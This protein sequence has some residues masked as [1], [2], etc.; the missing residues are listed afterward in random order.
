MKKTFDKLY[1]SLPSYLLPK[2]QEKSK[3]RKRQDE[4]DA[5]RKIV[6]AKLNECNDYNSCIRKIC[7][8][9]QS[10]MDDVIKLNEVWF[11]SIA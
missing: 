4:L 2:P 6:E 1:S 9:F 11:N 7:D 5:L 3:K 8:E 10:Q